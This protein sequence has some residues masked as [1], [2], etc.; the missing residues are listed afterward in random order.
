ML[1]VYSGPGLTAKLPTWKTV[2]AT[3][4]TAAPKTITIS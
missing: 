2:R 3:T 4:L 1:D